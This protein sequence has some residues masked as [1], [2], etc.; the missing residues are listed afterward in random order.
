MGNKTSDAKA[1]TKATPETSKVTQ[2]KKMKTTAKKKQIKS[3]EDVVV[4]TKTLEAMPQ[5]ELLAIAKAYAKVVDNAKKHKAAKKIKVEET[6]KPDD[7][8]KEPEPSVEEPEAMEEDE[9]ET[10]GDTQEHPTRGWT[11]FDGGIKV[12]YWVT[13]VDN[14]RYPFH[15]VRTMALGLPSIGGPDLKVEALRA[16][17]RRQKNGAKSTPETFA[18]FSGIKTLV[19]VDAGGKDLLSGRA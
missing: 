1:K 13:T 9:I 7:D 19:D 6:P 11:T 15:S 10:I 3:V 18:K 8:V 12:G 4:D 17:I 2:G 16:F 5:D 14:K